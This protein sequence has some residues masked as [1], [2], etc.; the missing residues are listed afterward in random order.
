MYITYMYIQYKINKLGRKMS[1]T[2]LKHYII[3]A[4]VI[5]CL[6][7]CYN[8]CPYQ[9]Y[10]QFCV[11]TSRLGVS[12]L[13]EYDRSDTLSILHLLGTAWLQNLPKQHRAAQ[14]SQRGK[15]CQGICRKSKFRIKYQNAL[16][17]TTCSKLF[18]NVFIMM[19]SLKPY[20]TVLHGISN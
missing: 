17:V 6:I 13:H 5:H 11:F 1:K 4:Y 9:T 20:V 14:S 12:V 19:A 8:V 10:K 3:N 2:E 18:Y 7:N 16:K 15:H